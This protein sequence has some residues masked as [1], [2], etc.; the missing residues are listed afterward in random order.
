MS[1]RRWMSLVVAVVAMAVGGCVEYEETV[2]IEDEAGSGRIRVEADIASHIASN[3]GRFGQYAPVVE[4][5]DSARK[6][7]Q[8]RNMQLVKYSRT[9]SGGMLHVSV[10]ATF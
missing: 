10:Q 1:Y 5:E 9:E 2:T 3:A 6:Y 4:G 7:L 8:E